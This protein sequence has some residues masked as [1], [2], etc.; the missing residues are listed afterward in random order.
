MTPITSYA[1]RRHRTQRFRRAIASHL[2]SWLERL[3]FPHMK[4]S[5]M[6]FSAMQISRANLARGWRKISRSGSYLLTGTKIKQSCTPEGR[7]VAENVM[8]NHRSLNVMYVIRDQ[9]I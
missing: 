1:L 6:S 7:V 2:P 3:F 9:R 8:N 4:V 5:S